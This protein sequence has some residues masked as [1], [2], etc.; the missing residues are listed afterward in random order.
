[1]IFDHSASTA[2]Y[3]ICLNLNLTG[4]W[5][6]MPLI[7]ALRGQ[8]QADLLSSRPA[9]RVSSRTARATQENLVLKKQKQTNKQIN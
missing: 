6:C 5:W 1:M 3:F 2:Y 8:R 4:Q 7:P 9:Y